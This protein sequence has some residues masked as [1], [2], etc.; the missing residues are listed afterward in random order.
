LALRLST[1]GSGVD[2]AVSV[3]S[4]VGVNVS[5]GIGVNVSGTELAGN[6]SAGE[7]IVGDDSTTGEGEAGVI[8][9]VK[10][11][12]RVVRTSNKG[13]NILFIS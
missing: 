13:S 6:V 12:A 10:L 9:P 11:Q 8:P 1:T 4:D 3:G 5:A 7:M 2:V